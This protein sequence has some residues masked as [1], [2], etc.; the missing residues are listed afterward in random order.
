M[1]EENMKKIQIINDTSDSNSIRVYETDC[2]YIILV[3]KDGSQYGEPYYI[4][5][6]DQLEEAIEMLQDEGIGQTDFLEAILFE[7]E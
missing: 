4:D 6:D 1:N 7:V 2:K 3:I 5:S